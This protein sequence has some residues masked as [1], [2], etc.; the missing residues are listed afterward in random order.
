MFHYHL[1]IG[2]LHVQC[3]YSASCLTGRIHYKSLQLKQTHALTLQLRITLGVAVLNIHKLWRHKQEHLSF[4][5]RLLF[6]FFQHHGGQ[7]DVRVTYI[8]TLKEKLWFDCAVFMLKIWIS[9]KWQ[10]KGGR[11]WKQNWDK[12]RFE[13]KSLSFCHWNESFRR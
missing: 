10:R 2:Y 7:A 4:K 1:I 13:M 5:S 6:C 9:Q 11:W 8:V 3:V 12:C